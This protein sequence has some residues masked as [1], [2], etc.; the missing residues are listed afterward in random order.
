M[1]GVSD[2]AGG[3]ARPRLQNL[4][5]TEAFTSLLGETTK[6]AGAFVSCEGTP[7]GGAAGAQWRRNPYVMPHAW[8]TD[9]VSVS[10]AGQPPCWI[11]VLI[12]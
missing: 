5:W 11:P 12:S 10:A 8:A 4:H 2:S 6:L 7:A 1:H 3:R 9:Q